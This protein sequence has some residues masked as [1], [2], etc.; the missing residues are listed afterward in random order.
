MCLNVTVTYLRL[1]VYR[2]TPDLSPGEFK[3]DSWWARLHWSN[4]FGFSLPNH[5]PS[6]VLCSS[7][8]AP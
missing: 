2:G 1:T 5:R 7:T 3:L 4:F 6:I 8:V